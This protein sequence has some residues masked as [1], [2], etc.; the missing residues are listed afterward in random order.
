MT[1]TMQCREDAE[2]HREEDLDRHLLGLLL[3]PLTTH[4]PH[5]LGLLAQDVGDRQAQPVGLDDGADEGPDLRGRR[6]LAHALERLAAGVADLD[7][8]QHAGELA[9]DRPLDRAGDL[10]QRAVEALA[11]LHADG[12]HVE[13]VGEAGPQL[14]LALQACVV[15]EQVREEQARCAGEDGDDHAGQ[16]EAAEEQAD[17]REEEHRDA[18]GPEDPLDRPVRRVAGDVEH[19]GEPV[20][21]PLRREGQAEAARPVEGRGEEAVASR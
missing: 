7:L 18:L 4:E 8:R 13:R 17:D 6:A 3:G 5:L 20:G 10:Q 21:G 15:D 2:E 14:V 12:E 19:L 9:G 1:T 11:G 16:G